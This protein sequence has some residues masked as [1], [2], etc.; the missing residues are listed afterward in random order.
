M[1]MSI[2]LD[3]LEDM[4]SYMQKLTIVFGGDYKTIHQFQ[5]IDMYMR[6]KEI[7]NGFL[8]YNPLTDD[9][10]YKDLKIIYE[11]GLPNDDISCSIEC[12]VNLNDLI[13]WKTLDHIL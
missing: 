3:T 13:R 9:G 5:E 2:L 8:N 11:I 6:I 12:Q 4:N 7:K 10:S 1:R